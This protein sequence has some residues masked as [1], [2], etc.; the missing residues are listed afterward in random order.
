MKMAG[1]LSS[2]LVTEWLRNTSPTMG[3]GDR[4]L[5]VLYRCTVLSIAWKSS[6][7]AR[8]S[9]SRETST[10]C[11]APAAEQTLLASRR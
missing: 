5:A 2:P 9:Q 3:V 4:S 6:P 7:K 8:V 10:T 11:Q 1:V